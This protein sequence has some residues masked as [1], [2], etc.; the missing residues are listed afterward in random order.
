MDPAG[1]AVDG[2]EFAVHLASYREMRN[3]RND[4]KRM[5]KRHPE[6][7]LGLEARVATVDLGPAKGTFHRLKAGPLP[8]RAFARRLCRSLR[9]RGL[10]CAV[11]RFTG[12]QLATVQGAPGASAQQMK[13]H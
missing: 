1:D 8:S 5:V 13:M 9:D 6:F 2:R 7:L 3:L 4:W 12:R 11:M 10:Y